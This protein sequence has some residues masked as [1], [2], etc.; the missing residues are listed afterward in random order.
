MVKH[1]LRTVGSCAAIASVALASGC[2]CVSVPDEK[3]EQITA[4]KK[5][6]ITWQSEAEAGRFT[7]A[8]SRSAAIGWSFL[9]GA[10]Q[11]F[12]AHKMGDAGIEATGSKIALRSEGTLMLMLSWIPFVYPVTLIGGMATGAMVDANRVNWLAYLRQREEQG[13][14]VETQQPQDEETAGSEMSAKPQSEP[15]PE[16][17]RDDSERQRKLADLQNRY[18]LGLCTEEEFNRERAQIMNATQKASEPPR[19]ERFGLEDGAPRR[20]MNL[21]SVRDDVRGLFKSRNR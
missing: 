9:P 15:S 7:P 13:L 11:H 14:A 1:K 5:Q 21:M 2:M 6:G 18:N 8:V 10:G 12:I 16:P 4:L 3:D 17:V 19:Q 20:G